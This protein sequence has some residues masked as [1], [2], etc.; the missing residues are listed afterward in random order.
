VVVSG[1]NVNQIHG[2]VKFLDQSNKEIGLSYVSAPRY[3]NDFELIKFS[4]SFITPAGTKHL[5]FELNSLQNPEQKS[6]WWIHD[7]KMKDLSAYTKPNIQNTTYRFSASG[8]YKVFIRTF[9]NIK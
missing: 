9:D 4:G 7:M 6:F 1:K 3:A 2:K 5:L 8:S